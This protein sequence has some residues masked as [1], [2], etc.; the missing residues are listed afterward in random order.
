MVDVPLITYVF[1]TGQ[2]GLLEFQSKHRR[3]VVGISTACAV[4]WPSPIAQAFLPRAV[5]SSFGPTN[6][7]LILVCC[8]HNFLCH[9]LTVQPDA[10]QDVTCALVRFLF[11]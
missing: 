9:G 6:L 4:Q 3:L 5:S 10:R 8:G 7:G 11:G 1:A 2:P